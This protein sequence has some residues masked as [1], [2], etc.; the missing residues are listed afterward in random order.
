[1]DSLAQGFDA[2]YGGSEVKFIN[3]STYYA[4]VL[5]CLPCI[6]LCASIYTFYHAIKPEHEEI[7]VGSRFPLLTL[8]CVFAVSFEPFE[9]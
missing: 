5:P 1:M 4:F 2:L 8:P 7:F 9:H 3:K 6:Y